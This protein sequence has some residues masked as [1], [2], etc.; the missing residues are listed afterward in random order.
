MFFLGRAYTN[1]APIAGTNA[2]IMV[3]RHRRLVHLAASHENPNADNVDIIPV[4]MLRR[5]VW[6]AENP[7]LL[8]MMPLNVIKPTKNISMS[9]RYNQ[10][11]KVF[12]SIG[13]VNS[14]IE[15]KDNPSLWVDDGLYCL[16]S[17]PRLTY[18]A[19]LVLRQ[20]SNDIVLF[21]LVQKPSVHWRVWKVQKGNE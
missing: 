19:S 21:S 14:N 6:T 18:N 3:T 17:F 15:E 5:D 20:A 12:T 10:G 1:I 8:T 13:Y 2:A 7:R 9:V 4:G 16:F 11:R